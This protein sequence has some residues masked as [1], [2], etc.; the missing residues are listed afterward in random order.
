MRLAENST[1][2]CAHWQHRRLT[3]PPQAPTSQ[4]DGMLATQTLASNGELS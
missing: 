4:R 3:H 2:P 1:S